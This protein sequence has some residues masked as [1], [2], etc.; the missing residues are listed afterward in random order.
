MRTSEDKDQFLEDLQT[1]R[2]RIL[3]ELGN[4]IRKNG[5]DYEKVEESEHAYIYAQRT[6]GVS[7]VIAYEVFQR[8][9]NKPYTIAGIA[10]PAS[11]AFPSN[12]SF[13]SWAFT[14]PTLASAE[15][16]FRALSAKG[17]EN[18]KA[19]YAKNPTDER[20]AGWEC[21]HC[22]DFFRRPDFR[23]DHDYNQMNPKCP[24]CGEW[25]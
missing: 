20:Q 3:K 14:Y 17:E 24:C 13:G 18:Q 6:K 1:Q 22:G 7:K 10:F 4:K 5:F 11:V 12:E 9:E 15:R 25:L 19:Q 23:F 21:R 8:R 16:K 2:G